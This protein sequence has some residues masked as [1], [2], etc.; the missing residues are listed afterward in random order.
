MSAN[1][2]AQNI[3]VRFEPG[4]YGGGGLGT[5]GCMG[6]CRWIGSQNLPFITLGPF[7]IFNGIS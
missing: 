3:L 4:V 7:V 5:N 6:A 2:N 1:T